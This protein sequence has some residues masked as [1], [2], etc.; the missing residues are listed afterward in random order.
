MFND[1]CQLFLIQ[2]KKRSLIM[3]RIRLSVAMVVF[4]AIIPGIYAQDWPQLLGPDRNGISPQKGV[5][6]TWPQKG[7][8]VLWN[9]NIGIGYGGP[10]IKDGKAYILDRDDKVGDKL[11]CF[12]MTT[13]KELWNYAYEA[14]GSVMFPGSRSVPSIDGNRIYTCG[15]YGQFYCIDIETH[16]PVWNKNIWT[17]FGGTEIPRWAVA[18]CPLIYGDL[19]IVASQAPQAGVVAYNK[20]TGELKWKTPSIGNTGYVSPSLVKI[21]GEDHVVMIS[22]SQRGGFGQPGTGA[23]VVG[24]E[25]LTGKILWEYTNFQCS[26]PVPSPIDA[27][28][29]RV[30]ITGGYNAGS[31]L[32]KVEKKSDGSYNVAELFRNMEV[33]AH[34]L[35]AILFNGNFY[36][37]CSTNEKKDGLVCLGIDG[38]VKWKTGM[39]PVFERGS[40]VLADGLILSTDGLTKLYL[41]E[42]DPGSFKPIASAEVL[43]SG[44]TDSSDQMSSRVGGSVQN[45]APIALSDGKLLIRD[46]NKLA[47]VKVVK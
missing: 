26:I 24:I 27:G 35:P 33:G 32:V 5:L 29:N 39:E 2:I 34:T 36:M 15:P 21:S 45:W 19:V 41:I 14:P 22:A 46:Q 10:V 8:E 6:R 12:D 9:V 4:M 7:P 28:E 3:N 25:P 1:P 37:H 40:L 16:K 11:R 18:Q 13:G 44:G 23:R 42:P 43:A 17:D 30:F 47:C 38:R 31:A 20:L